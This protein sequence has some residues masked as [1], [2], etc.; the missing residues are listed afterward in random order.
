MGVLLLS[1]LQLRIRAGDDLI[2]L[3]NIIDQ[4]LARAQLLDKKMA[5]LDELDKKGEEKY[6]NFMVHYFYPYAREKLDK[7]NYAS[8]QERE[9]AVCDEAIKLNREFGQYYC[10][11]MKQIPN[12][13]VLRQPPVFESTTEMLENPFK[14]KGLE[15][16]NA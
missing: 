15:D 3:N 11:K 7:G 16:I 9:Q 2:K 4:E 14:R 13:E 6:G 8:N 12:P 10:W 1:I 5:R